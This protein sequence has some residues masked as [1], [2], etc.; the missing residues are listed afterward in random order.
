MSALPI[1]LPNGVIAI[2][3]D[4]VRE[5]ASGVIATEAY[6]FGYVDKVWDGGEV[7]VYGGDSVMFAKKDIIDRVVYTSGTYTLVPAR[8]VTKEDNPMV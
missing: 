5:S 2:Y 3:G 4:G 8:L 6:L 7:Y 1:T